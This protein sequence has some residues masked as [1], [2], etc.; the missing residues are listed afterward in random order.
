MDQ[1]QTQTSNPARKQWGP[2]RRQ[3]TSLGTLTLDGEQY[4]IMDSDDWEERKDLRGA[5]DVRF[6][7]R[8][9]D[10]GKD[11]R[12]APCLL[13]ILS[14]D[15]APAE[16]ASEPASAPAPSA[17]L[18]EDIAAALQKVRD[19]LQV[20][21]SPEALMSAERDLMGALAQVAG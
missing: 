1:Q 14:A 7:R 6:Y 4:D 8:K 21:A 15:L 16:P 10:G 12:C 11:P 3:G 9:R 5:G 19:M 2:E 20:G 17:G 18:R 13:G